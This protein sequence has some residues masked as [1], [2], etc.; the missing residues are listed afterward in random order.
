M[1]ASQSQVPS[2]QFF[3][4]SFK[5]KKR[6]EFAQ[7]QHKS[8][9]ITVDVVL[10]SYKKNHFNHGRL[11]L[12]LTRKNGSSVERNL[13]KRRVRELFRRSA[14]RT[15]PY[16]IVVRIRGELSKVNWELLQTAFRQLE[17]RLD[18]I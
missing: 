6:K 8:S 16:D 12:V 18:P 11:G 1:I 13:C 9:K 5:L 3:P 2:A 15:K 14:I 10:V 7:H 17:E 4:A